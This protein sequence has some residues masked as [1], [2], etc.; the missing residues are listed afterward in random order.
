VCTRDGCPCGDGLVLCA[1]QCV[2]LSSAQHCGTCS[3]RC[4]L[5]GS[6]LACGQGPPGV[7][8]CAGDDTKCGGNADT[9]KCVSPSGVCL[10]S[11]VECAR[12]E[13]CRPNPKGVVTCSC[14]GA[15]ACSSGQS[16][17]QGKGC[18]NLTTAESD[19]GLC[20]H[21]CPAGF[22]CNSGSC[23]C[24]NKI[25]CDAGGGGECSSTGFCQCGS[26]VCSAGQQCV[27]PGICG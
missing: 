6:A 24:G 3:N 27:A 14:D 21:A 2:T 15:A 8:T 26:S 25:A 12:G 10:C 11:N 1:S 4:D 16:C 18:I 22:R 9:A 17:C 20:G 19:C 13:L 7:C 23:R 5:L